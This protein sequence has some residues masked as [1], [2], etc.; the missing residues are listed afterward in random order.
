MLRTNEQIQIENALA[1]A[2]N[3]LKHRDVSAWPAMFAEDGVQEFPFAAENAPQIVRGRNNIAE[4]LS[5]YPEK[6]E[7][8]RIGTLIWHHD[9]ETAVVQFEIDGVALLTGNPYR[10]RYVGF[11][12]H[13]AG[14]INRYVD[15]WNPMVVQQALSGSPK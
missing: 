11:I 4:Y 12:E 2:L 6:F 15:Y 14:K 10:Q 5:D 8:H 1:N 9:G 13:S 7:L 3:A